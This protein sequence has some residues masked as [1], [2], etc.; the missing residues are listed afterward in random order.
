MLLIENTGC[1]ITVSL[2]ESLWKKKII[3]VF[4]D[5]H[6]NPGA[7]LLPFTARFES[8][9]QLFTQ[10]KWTKKTKAVVWAKIVRMKI[11]KQAENLKSINSEIAEKVYSYSLDVVAGDKTNREG[12]AAKVYFNALFSPEFARDIEC[13]ENAALNYGY[14]ILLSCVNRII[15]TYGYS[16]QLG[17]FHKNTF[18]QFNLGCDLMEPF[19]PIFDSVTKNAISAEFLS[20]EDKYRIQNTVN[21]RIWIDDQE[22]TV[23]NALQIYIRSVLNA[24]DEDNPLLIKDYKYEF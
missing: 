21:D 19:R 6:R 1:S 2:L 12:H 16:T 22:T 17:I 10:L 23:L 3:V 4:C 8:N 9:S 24:L 15:V 20:Q 11:T 14:S 5:S 18:N 13:F 7:Q